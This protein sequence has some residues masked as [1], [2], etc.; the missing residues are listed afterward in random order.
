MI[1]KLSPRQ[2]YILHLI[3]ENKGITIDELVRRLDVSRRTVQR[4]INALHTYLDKYQIAL[5]TTGNGFWLIGTRSD[6][7]R[8]FDSYGD[9]PVT[10][11]L[12]AKDRAVYAVLEL[13]MSSGPLKLSYLAKKLKVTSSSISSDLSQ[14]ANL[15]REKNL[16]L[17]RRRGYG[18]EISG[19]EASRME[20]V[21]EIIHEQ[22]SVYELMTFLRGQPY[23]ENRHSV[24][25]WLSNWFSTDRLNEVRTVLSE[26]L[27][28]LNPPLDEAAFYSFMLHTLLASLRLET[29]CDLR[30]MDKTDADEPS[31]VR[32]CREILHKLVPDAQGVG[33]EAEYLARHLRGAKVQMTEENKVLPQ[34]ITTMDLSF[35]LIEELSRIL[36]MPLSRDRELLFGL[37]QHL[38]PAIYRL[39]TGLSIRNPLLEEVKSRYSDYFAAVREASDIV[40]GPYGFKVPDGEIGYLTMHLGAALERLKAGNVW[41]VKI[42]CPNGI[43]SAELLAS[44]IQS[45]FPQI[46]IVSVDAIHSLR[47][48][49]CDFMV[50]TVPIETHMIPCVTVSPFLNR[51]DISSIQKVLQNLERIFSP[52]KQIDAKAEASDESVTARL[53]KQIAR[54]A[55]VYTTHV[56][57]KSALI[58]FI[59]ERVKEAGDAASVEHIARAIEERERLG[60]IVL[61]GKKFAVLHARSE[62]VIKC[63]VSVYRL[64]SPILMQSV[65]KTSDDVDSVL[66]LLARADE[67]PVVIKL[68]GRLSSALVME[69]SILEILRTSEIENVREC[70]FYALNQTQE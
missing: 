43:S 49:D 15:L 66:V 26:E 4:D 29:D 50:S 2:I 42:V 3:D 12:T 59:A 1:Q 35:H 34:S 6:L 21:T 32:L 31:E 67:D 7:Y 68:L 54:H 62:D 19:D 45:E 28:S 24:E 63:H 64:D 17:I 20:A 10:I 60:S 57:T 13:L 37:A 14:F 61:P 58:W 65:G 40:F 47:D 36:R 23:E 46:R 69:E 33:A 41:R 22:L 18:I 51:E 44:R 48:T 52:M 55:E 39:R 25:M 11:A 53:A 9:M 8:A 27:A 38:E 30:K 56:Q 70:I 5:D 16:K